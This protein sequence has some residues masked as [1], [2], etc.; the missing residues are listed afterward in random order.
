MARA[1]SLW[2]CWKVGSAAIGA[3][4]SQMASMFSRVERRRDYRTPWRRESAP[5]TDRSLASDGG[6]GGRVPVNRFRGAVQRRLSLAATGREPEAA[7]ARL[8]QRLNKGVGS[9]HGGCVMGLLTNLW[10]LFCRYRSC[11]YSASSSVCVRW[12]SSRRLGPA[13]RSPPVRPRVSADAAAPLALP[14][15][16]E[17]LRVDFFLRGR[18]RCTVFAG[19]LRGAPL[20][21]PIRVPW[22]AVRL[23]KAQSFLSSPRMELHTADGPP[24]R[25]ALRGVAWNWIRDARDRAMRAAA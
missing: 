19:L 3:S 11:C 24:I 20:A 23:V 6:P 8:V 16:V 15:R 21:P 22:S 17:E 2:S 12:G 10:Y 25:I 1:S 13:R 9:H 14:H 4:A 7:S 18:R 5:R